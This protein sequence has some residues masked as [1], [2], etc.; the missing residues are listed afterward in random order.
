M[1]RCSL[2]RNTRPKAIW[3]TLI[4]AGIGA[5]GNVIGSYQQAKAQEEQAKMYADGIRQQNENAAKLQNQMI[6]VMKAENEKN[7]QLMATSSLNE[8]IQMGGENA[9]SIYNMNR[10]VLRM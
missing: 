1:K 8:A 6:D 5:L 9:K 4:G 3:G 7:R 2:K 10:I